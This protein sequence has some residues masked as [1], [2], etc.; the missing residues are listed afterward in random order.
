MILPNTY[1]RNVVLREVVLLEHV[2]SLSL[3]ICSSPFELIVVE[4]CIGALVLPHNAY[5][6][7]RRIPCDLRRT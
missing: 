5:L 6:V 4:S 2:V 7:A 1:V 3:I